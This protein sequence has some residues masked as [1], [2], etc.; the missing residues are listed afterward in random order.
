MP[1]F[2]L[3]FAEFDQRKL[4]RGDRTI[5]V[6]GGDGGT[7]DGGLYGCNGKF[8]PISCLNE[9]TVNAFVAVEDKRFYSHHG[10]D[11]LRVLSAAKN[12]F[13]SGRAKEGA[14]T[15]TQQLVKNTHL[16]NEK[17][18]KRKINEIYNSHRN[19]EIQ[20]AN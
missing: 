13:I 11:Y 16:S 10:V 7:V 2:D 4:I 20:K 1:C 6:A 14:S 15:I 8:C 19:R 5:T 3:G 12:N 9:K 18:L 17:T